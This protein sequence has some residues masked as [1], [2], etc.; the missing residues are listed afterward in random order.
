[1]AEMDGAL[2]DAIEESVV[3]VG[4]FYQGVDDDTDLIMQCLISGAVQYYLDNYE[5]EDLQETVDR[6]GEL[7][8]KGISTAV[9]CVR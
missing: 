5:D 7:I 3:A 8:K 6:V 1:M 2:E 4:R 9:S